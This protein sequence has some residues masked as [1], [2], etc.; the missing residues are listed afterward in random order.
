MHGIIINPG[1]FS[2]YSIAIY[3][4]LKAINIPSIEVHLSDISKREDFR[5]KSFTSH[6][7][8]KTYMGKGF[9]SYLEALEFLVGELNV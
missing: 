7:C 2:H 4:A 3:D 8:L 9:D 6:A 1:A 5:K